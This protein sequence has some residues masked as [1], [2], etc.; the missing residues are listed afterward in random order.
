VYNATNHGQVTNGDF[1]FPPSANASVWELMASFDNTLPPELALLRDS[2]P[3]QSQS[4]GKHDPFRQ[5]FPS[6]LMQP[7]IAINGQYF[8][9][10][11][12]AMRY[13]Q[14]ILALNPIRSNVSSVPWNNILDAAFF[15]Q[16]SGSGA[17]T[18][19]NIVNIFSLALKQ[20][21]VST[22]VS[23]FNDLGDFFTQH[24]SYYGRLLIQRFPTQGMQRVPDQATA[25][26]FR[27]AK[28]QL[29]MEGWYTNRTL[30]A[31]VTDFLRAARA[32]F[33]E[34]SGFADL[35]VYTNYAHG[36]EGPEAWYSRRKLGRLVA[37]KK[38]WDPEGA[39]SWYNAVPHRH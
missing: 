11:E 7:V 25:Y 4:T 15:G 3:Q 28:I 1:L 16:T 23:H 14:P 24:P 12:Q 17:C 29:N 36:D 13:F 32:K 19:N 6:D 20:T 26:P 2:R 27:D 18:R 10:K 37:L 22:W 33:Q 21:D 5:N 8:G 34:T 31:P 9:P 35:S 38:R 39:F 30:D